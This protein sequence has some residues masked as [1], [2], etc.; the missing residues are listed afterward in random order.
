MSIETLMQAA[1]AAGYAMAPAEEYLIEPAHILPRIP[2][3]VTADV[4]LEEPF[5]L[6]PASHRTALVVHPAHHPH[7]P[8]FDWTALRDWVT[9]WWGGRATP[10]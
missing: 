4:E 2:A 7:H 9:N 1:R 6:A 8:P 3:P 10:A 5:E